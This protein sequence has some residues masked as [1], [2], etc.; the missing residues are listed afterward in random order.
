LKDIRSSFPDFSTKRHFPQAVTLNSFNDKPVDKI[1]KNSREIGDGAFPQTFPQFFK[2]NICEDLFVMSV[3]LASQS[4]ARKAM[5]KSAG[6]SFRAVPPTINESSLKKSL[7]RL[8]PKSLSGYLAEAKAESLAGT[9]PDVIIIGSDQTLEFEGEMI[10]KPKSSIEAAR[11]LKA[12]RGKTH[13][14]HSAVVCFHHGKLVWRAV[15]SARLT[16]RSF[17]DEFLDNYLDKVGHDISSSVGGY[18]IEGLG[19]QLFERVS[20]DHF[21]ILGMPLLSLLAFLRRKGEISV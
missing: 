8:D 5:L 18:K 19:L 16:M 12:M 20:G 14:L 15:K 2:P 21:V 6:V 11:Q 1:A 13:F 9:F 7:A 3:I 4:S 10:S 17:T